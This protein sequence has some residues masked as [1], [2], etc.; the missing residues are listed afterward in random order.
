MRQA[1]H[2]GIPG[3]AYIG[4]RFLWRGSPPGGLKVLDDGIPMNLIQRSA[5]L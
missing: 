2:R 4:V 5:W 1:S 3:R